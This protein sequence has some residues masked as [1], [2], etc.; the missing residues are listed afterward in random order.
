MR[1]PL[2]LATAIAALS[3]P[4]VQAQDTPSQAEMWKIIQQQQKEIQQL[5]SQIQNSNSQIQET[6]VMVS[7][8]ADAVEAMDAGGTGSSAQW[9][10]KTAIGGYGEHHYN[11]FDKSD[12]KVDAH[13][14][15]MFLSHQFSD[16]VKFFSE[17]ELE[18]SL[19]GEGKPGEVEL[20]QAYIQWDYADG[21]S[22]LMGQYLVPV[23]ILNETHEPDTFY[24]VERNKVESNIVPATW[25]ETGAM[26]QGEI[27]PGLSYNA[28]IHSGL[29]MDPGGTVRGGRQK[30]ANAVAEDPAYT[31]RLK[32]TGVP[33]LELAA[34]AQYQSELT[35]GLAMDDANGLLLETHAV[36]Q[37]GPFGVRALWAA[38]DIDGDDFE[39]AGRDEQEGWFLEPSFRAMENLGFFVRYSE[40]N[41]S[42][43]LSSS[44]DVETWD[45]GLNYWLHPRVVVKAD[46]SDVR[47]G[48]NDSVN[49]GVGWS[50]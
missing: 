35:Q 46:Y 49:V 29:K 19:A 17:V 18:H 24:G 5:K 33:G 39:L 23:G 47:D 34:T 38:W 7:A 6:R 37:N 21:H 10:E 1:N 42:A 16:N 14:Y 50:F 15:V 48:G 28:A 25:W 12:D 40:Y 20:E 31:F 30:S 41:N 3:S 13:R 36:Y 32:Y 22:L 8:T 9:T 43:G 2:L 45:Y 11:H 44:N 4:L 26:L 27:I